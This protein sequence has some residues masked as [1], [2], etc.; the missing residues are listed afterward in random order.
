[1]SYIRE[2]KRITA[3]RMIN[4]LLIAIGLALI[5]FGVL[6]VYLILNVPA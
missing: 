4:G 3:N 6:I 5:V 1:M 2:R